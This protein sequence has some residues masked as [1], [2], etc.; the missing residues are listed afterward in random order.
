MSNFT[1]PSLGIWTLDF[2]NYG[3]PMPKRL[4][5]QANCSMAQRHLGHPLCSAFPFCKK[6][7]ATGAGRGRNSFFKLAYLF[8]KIPIILKNNP[9]TPNNMVFYQKEN[10]GGQRDNTVG[11]AHPWHKVNPGSR[12][13][14]PCGTPR[15]ARSD[16]W[17]Q[18]SKAWAL[19]G[20]VPK[21][22]TKKKINIHLIL[23]TYF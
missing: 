5:G 7:K 21:P 17:T 3:N 14:T 9:Y 1:H 16:P 4:G 8:Y 6:E 10:T 19:S 20:V 12:P 18:R 23:L 13:S 11:R 15:P 22:R 2:L